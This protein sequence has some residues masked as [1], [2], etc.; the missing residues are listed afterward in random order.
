MVPIR[1]VCTGEARSVDGC[2]DHYTQPAEKHDAASD[3]EAAAL[4]QGEELGNE[5]HQGDAA[6][7][8]GQDHKRLDRFH[9]AFIFS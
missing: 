9:S 6:E 4:I 1:S 7:D 3:V 5:G 2:S 8:D